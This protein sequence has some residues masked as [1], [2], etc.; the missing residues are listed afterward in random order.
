MMYLTYENKYLYIAKNAKSEG[1][2]GSMGKLGKRN[3]D[4]QTTTEIP[5]EQRRKPKKTA[6]K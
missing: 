3:K 5:A 4:T 1:E 6:K 2:K